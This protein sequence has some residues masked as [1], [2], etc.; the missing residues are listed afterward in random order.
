MTFPSTASKQLQTPPANGHAPFRSILCA[1]DG[2]HSPE[3]V[4][5]ATFLA[6]PDVDVTFLSVAYRPGD[7]GTALGLMSPR[8]A[9]EALGAACGYATRQGLVPHRELI[10]APNARD[11]ILERAQDHDLLV[12][13]G[14]V[15]PRHAGILLGSTASAA[16][17]RVEIPVLLARSA[18]VLPRFPEQILV[19]TDGSDAASAAVDI[20]GDIAARHGSHVSLVH[21]RNGDEPEVRRRVAEQAADLYRKLE[22][23]PVA[24]T[25]RPPAHKAILEAAERDGCSL[26]VVGSRGLH[27]VAALGSVS[28]RVAHRARC[29]VLIVHPRP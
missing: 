17:H 25:G 12:L 21:V 16:V 28:E 5:Q 27:G 6:G 9:R 2:G 4:R 8:T 22:T 26:L 15:A 14:P 19:A 7:G 11:V 23:E 10:E 13:G 18:P 1:V 24:H 29:S 20:A 3:A